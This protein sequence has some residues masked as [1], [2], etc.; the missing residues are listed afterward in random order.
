MNFV[1]LI[2]TRYLL[3]INLNRLKTFN[4]VLYLYFM[5]TI[6]NKRYPFIVY[7]DLL[8]FLLSMYYSFVVICHH[9]TLSIILVLH[10]CTL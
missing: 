10:F 8:L 3:Q 7:D 9:T 1:E 4:V 6:S 5:C 2:W